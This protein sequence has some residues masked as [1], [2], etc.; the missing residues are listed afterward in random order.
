MP[1]KT[2]LMNLMSVDA[3]LRM[4]GTR[5]SAHATRSQL[6]QQGYVSIDR[7][8]RLTSNTAL[9][10]LKNPSPITQTSLIP[11]PPIP[12]LCTDVRSSLRVPPINSSLSS[13][14]PILVS[15]TLPTQYPLPLLSLPRLNRPPG[16]FDQSAPRPPCIT[17]NLV[18]PNSK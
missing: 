14:I 11:L 15:T 6:D 1:L 13:L 3:L 17:G 4:S 5:P 8:G 12:P 10:P 7:R 9:V 18:V 16:M 2:K